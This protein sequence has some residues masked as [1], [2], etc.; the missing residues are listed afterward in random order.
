MSSAPPPIRLLIIDDSTLVRE[1]LRVVLSGGTGGRPIEVVGESGTIGAGVEAARR[2][3]PDI[4]L[5]DIRL[6]DG[7]GV[8][9]C[10]QI[11]LWSPASRI[12]M[13]TSM[14]EDSIVMD[15]IK[16]GAHGYLLKEI[17]SRGLLSA[18][19]DVSEGKS[20]LD[21]AITARVMQMARH[22]E[23]GGDALATL[24]PQEKRIIGLIAEGC[25]NKE[26]ALKLGLSEKTVKNYLSTAFEKLHVSSRAQ[27]AAL[28]V[29]NAERTRGG[30][31]P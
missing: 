2:L 5:L 24:S 30:F 31:Q 3:K 13:L 28:F 14:V 27:A 7:S 22:Q 16:A 21:P 25:T 29:K 18:I 19:R 15:A 17:D 12:L 1:G 6:P 8:D 20:I 11:L 10:R 9:A 23:S 26:A 4:I